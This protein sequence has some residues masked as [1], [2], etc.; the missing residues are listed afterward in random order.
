MSCVICYDDDQELK[1]LV[2]SHQFC[3]KCWDKYE[4]SCITQDKEINCCLCRQHSYRNYSWSALWSYWY[5][6]FEDAMF[7][8][9]LQTIGM[10]D[11]TSYETY[12]G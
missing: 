3:Y 5:G 1:E 8:Y 9:S 4:M 12:W 10:G 7:E 2:C 11:E 6:I